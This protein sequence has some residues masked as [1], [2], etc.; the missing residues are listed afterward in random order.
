M[1]EAALRVV[2]AGRA[3][4]LR[5]V[6]VGKAAAMLRVVR[7][8]KAAVMLR[9]VRACKSATALYLPSESITDMNPVQIPAEAPRDTAEALRDMPEARLRQA[10]LSRVFPLLF[11]PS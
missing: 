7:A 3:A 1:A 11:Q 8:C 4:A 9:V 10:R 6:R 5:V 2:R